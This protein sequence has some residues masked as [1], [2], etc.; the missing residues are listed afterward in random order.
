MP[1]AHLNDDQKR[2]LLDFLF[3]R[4]LPKSNRKA[5]DPQRPDFMYLTFQKLLDQRGYPGCKPPW[6]TLNAIN[7]NTGKLA[8]KVPLGEHAEL[9]LEGIDK[10]GT[11]NLGGP[12]VTAGGVVFCA[13]TQDRLI[14]AFDGKTGA[15][16]WQHELPWGGYAP[17]S[18][19]QVKGKQYI[20]IAATGGGTL[21]GPTGDAYVAFSLP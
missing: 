2:I 6:G 10:T 11:E 20:V 17:P 16:L 9:T 4:D 7:L 12:T 8:W 5:K 3:D 15:E 13:G 18:V 14:R 1:A 21:G 19:Y